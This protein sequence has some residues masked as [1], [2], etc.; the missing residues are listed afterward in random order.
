[1]AG[2][3]DVNNTSSQSAFFANEF[4][5]S[6]FAGIGGGTKTLTP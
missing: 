5:I 6:S 2:N 3:I 4:G 1:V